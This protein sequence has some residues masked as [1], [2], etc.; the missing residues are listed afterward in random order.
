MLIAMATYLPILLLIA[1]VITLGLLA[2]GVV[3][4]VRRGGTGGAAGR[5]SNRLMQLRIVFQA[6]ALVLFV[7]LM[8]VA[9]GAGR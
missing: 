5:R 7:L 9:G 2:V 4:M 1:M 8:L 3:G 6:G